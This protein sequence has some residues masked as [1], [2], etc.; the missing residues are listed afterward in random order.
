MAFLVAHDRQ[1]QQTETAS[2][3]P[4]QVEPL[5]STE[6]RRGWAVLWGCAV[7][8]CFPCQSEKAPDTGQA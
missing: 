2:G 7:P 4:E 6:K 8:G 1:Q 3:R 5:Y